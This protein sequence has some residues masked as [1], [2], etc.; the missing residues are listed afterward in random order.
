MIARSVVCA[1]VVDSA[2]GYASPLDAPVRVTLT[3]SKPTEFTLDSGAVTIDSG[4]TYSY[5]HPDTLRF[6]GVD[7]VGA[8]ILSSAPGSTPDSSN[9]IKVFPTPLQLNRGDPYTVGPGL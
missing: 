9:V 5:T 2:S 1:V 8:R 7:T 4:L 3:S 6:R